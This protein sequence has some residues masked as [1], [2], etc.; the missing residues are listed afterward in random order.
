MSVNCSNTNL[1]QLIAGGL[2]DSQT[3]KSLDKVHKSCR[4]DAQPAPLEQG[5]RMVLPMSLEVKNEEKGRKPRW[6]RK[7]E[8]SV[9]R[10]DV[11]EREERAWLW[12]DLQIAS[13][14]MLR[15]R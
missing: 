9:R 7:A 10:R 6:A 15:Q 12:I 2:L 11:R 4:H 8:I 5:S 13:L 14:I 1:N 3:L